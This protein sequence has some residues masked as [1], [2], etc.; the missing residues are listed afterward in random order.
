MPNAL[1]LFTALLLAC[2]K[3]NGGECTDAAGNIREDGESWQCDAECTVCCNPCSCND[4]MVV[5]ALLDCDPSPDVC[6]DSTGRYE[7]GD[8]W[9]CPDGC[10]TCACNPDSTIN[11]TDM[12]CAPAD[13]TDATGTHAS[14]ESWAC[15][16][17]CNTCSCLEDGNIASTRIACG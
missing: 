2:T 1:A 7:A 13:C 3:P 5:E 6:E 4:G 10:N 15:P 9:T 16:D 14:G 8:I 12:N 11:S 17:G